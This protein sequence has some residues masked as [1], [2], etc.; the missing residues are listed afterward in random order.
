MDGWYFSGDM[1]RIDPDGYLFFDGRSKEMIKSNGYSVFPE[2]VERMLVRHPGIRQAAVI[3]VDDAARGQSA[4]AFLV[5]E[6]EAVGTL[7]EDTVI[8]WAKERMAAY[9]YPRSVRF[10][11]EIPQTSTGKMLRMKLRDLD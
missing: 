8:A 7:D 3:G 5:L 1:G 2:E 10:I 6:P 4:R 9:K 11:E